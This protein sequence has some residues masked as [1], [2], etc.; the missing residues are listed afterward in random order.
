MQT[1]SVPGLVL[2]AALSLTACAEVAHGPRIVHYTADRFYIRSVPVVT[3]W[4]SAPELA[5]IVCARTQR[6]PIL[7]DAEQFNPIDIR[8]STYRCVADEE[9]LSMPQP[10]V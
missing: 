5:A 3:T 8:Y 9:L 1:P 10:G 6:R 7:D 4:P 2:I